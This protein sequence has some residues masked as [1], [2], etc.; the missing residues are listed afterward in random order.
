MV[1]KIATGEIEE[2]L[3]AKSGRSRS[4]KAGGAARSS[5]LTPQRRQAIAKTAAQK[6]LSRK[7]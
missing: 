4:G 2:R 7:D 1:M 3:E 6:R 5:K